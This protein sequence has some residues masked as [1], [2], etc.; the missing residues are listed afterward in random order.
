LVVSDASPLIYL[1][2]TGWLHLLRLLF[3]EVQVPEEVKTECV[4][5]GKEKGYVD[6]HV[7][8]KALHDKLIVV[9]KLTNEN[10][11]KAMNLAEAFGVDYGETQAILLAQQKGERQILLDETHA[12]KAARSL[13]ITPK[14]TI[15]VIIAAIKR[16]H[17]SK[18]DG[19]GILDLIVE[20]NFHISL[21]IYKKALKTIER[22]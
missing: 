21:K 3:E 9:H 17:I 4:D 22:L 8:E 18:T 10:K 20:A 1:A 2:R 11:E 19:K 7:I 5:R 14:G 6:A 16:G 12:R 15:Y 13:G